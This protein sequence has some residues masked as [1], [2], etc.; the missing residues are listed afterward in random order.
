MHVFRRRSSWSRYHRRAWCARDRYSRGRAQQDGRRRRPGRLAVSAIRSFHSRLS[1]R[2]RY[3]GRLYYL[4]ARYHE[5][6]RIQ[7]RRCDVG[8]DKVTNVLHFG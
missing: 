1:L 3:R 7:V 8:A 2:Q 4:H 6:E 5:A